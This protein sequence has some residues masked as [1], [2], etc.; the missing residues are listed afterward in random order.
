MSTASRSSVALHAAARIASA[1]LLRNPV[2]S[3]PISG[4]GFVTSYDSVTRVPL[5]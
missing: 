1:V 4:I 3:H 2:P 5:P